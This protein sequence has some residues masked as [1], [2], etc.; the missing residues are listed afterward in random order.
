MLQNHILY[1]FTPQ[2]LVHMYNMIPSILF[3]L[4]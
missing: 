4:A 2:V 1:S 3:L